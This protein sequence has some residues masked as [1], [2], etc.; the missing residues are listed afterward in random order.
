MQLTQENRRTWWLVMV[1]TWMVTAILILL[2]TQAVR[3]YVAL[4]DGLGLNGAK[5][6]GTLLRQVI[7]S[8]HA[9]GQMWV[10]HALAARES[11]QAR[12]R[13]TVLDNAPVGREVHWNSAFPWMIRAAGSLH[14]AMSGAASS[15]AML[16]G[17]SAAFVLGDPFVGELRHFVA[18]GR[19]LPASVRQSGFPAV[20]YDL[21]SVLILV[22]ATILLLRRR[23]EARIVLGFLTAVTAGWVAMAFL[24]MRWWLNG[25]GPQIGLLLC[26]LAAGA[27]AS[28]RA[29]WLAVGAA[30]A[31]LLL[32]AGIMRIVTARIEN[33]DRVVS[34]GDL[35]QPLYRDL[36]ATL[37]ETQPEGDIIL[38]AN[39]NAGMQLYFQGK[40]KVTGDP[41]LATKLQKLFSLG[42]V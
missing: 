31:L 21:A 20:A 36:A 30:V 14:Q 27:G 18:E 4:I 6:A 12:V 16:A 35:L 29:R 17:G 25:S 8:R 38:L 33:R 41:M 22:P 28:P 37:R 15:L 11:H 40:L 3:D 26:L 24:E 5:E 1:A 42:A 7:P 32:P 39:P 23:D 19:S 13:F 10:R 9:D 2:H 34:E